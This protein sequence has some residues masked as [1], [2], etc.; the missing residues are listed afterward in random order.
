MSSKQRQT[1]IDTIDDLFNHGVLVIGRYKITLRRSTQADWWKFNPVLRK[2]EPAREDDTGRYKI[3]DGVTPWQQL[4]Y[5]DSKIQEM[6][7]AI[8]KGWSAGAC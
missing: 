8:R 6:V 1:F 3:G 4:P 2:A 7:N 5:L